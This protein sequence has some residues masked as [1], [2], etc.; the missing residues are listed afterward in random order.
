MI[1]VQYLTCQPIPNITGGQSVSAFAFQTARDLIPV[2][3]VSIQDAEVHH[4]AQLQVDHPGPHFAP[5]PASAHW[6]LHLLLPGQLML[7]DTL[8][9]SVWGGGGSEESSWSL[10]LKGCVNQV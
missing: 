2:V 10:E 9:S 3:H 7:V 4:L 8:G 6:S 1:G 5:P